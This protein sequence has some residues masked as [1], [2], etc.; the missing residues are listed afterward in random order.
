MIQYRVTRPF[1]Y[2]FGTPGYSDPS[3]RQ[4]YYVSANDTEEATAIIRKRLKLSRTE[5]LD[6]QKW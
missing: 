2:S 5:K 6:I 3:A 4:G 1:V